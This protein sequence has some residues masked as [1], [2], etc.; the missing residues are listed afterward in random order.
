LGLPSDSSRLDFVVQLRHAVGIPWPSELR[1]RGFLLSWAKES[2]LPDRDYREP[3]VPPS[4]D[5]SQTQGSPGTSRLC[6]ANHGW[7]L[8]LLATKANKESRIIFSS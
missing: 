3:R 5:P 2:P 7:M 6:S 1:L 8:L 4:S